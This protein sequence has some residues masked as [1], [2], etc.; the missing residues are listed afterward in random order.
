MASSEGE[1]LSMKILQ[2]Q[3]IIDAKDRE[4]QIL[5]EKASQD[6]EVGATGQQPCYASTLYGLIAR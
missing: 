4:M 5:R 6:P 1:D 2:L 3:C